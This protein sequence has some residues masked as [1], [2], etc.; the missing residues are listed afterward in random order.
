[1]VAFPSIVEV[2]VLAVLLIV[3]AILITLLKAL[4]FYLPAIVLAIVVLWVTH[5]LSWCGV[6]FCA[7]ALLSILKRR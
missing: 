1:M 6:A 2:L 7:V 5:S 4:I 3:G